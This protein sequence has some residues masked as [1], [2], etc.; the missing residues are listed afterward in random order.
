MVDGAQR[1][2]SHVDRLVMLRQLLLL[3]ILHC[4]AALLLLLLLDK[5][6][7]LAEVVQDVDVIFDLLG[8]TLI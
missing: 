5:D 7:V 8:E 1:L 4:E 3:L 6:L 2:I